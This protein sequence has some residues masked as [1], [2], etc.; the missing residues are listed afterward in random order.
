MATGVDALRRGLT[1]AGM[2]IAEAE[3]YAKR[4]SPQWSDDA[5][6]LKRKAEGLK[7]D[8]EAVAKGAIFGKAG[9]VGGMVP[10][11]VPLDAIQSPELGAAPSDD[12]DALVE[13]YRS[14]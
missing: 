5:E 4:Y 1:G 12:I 9:M 11:P 13:Q 10:K 6:T 2:A 8:L 7:T 3:E 14:K